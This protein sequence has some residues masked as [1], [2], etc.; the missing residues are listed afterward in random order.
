M[1]GALFKYKCGY[2][3]PYTFLDILFSNTK[4]FII[5]FK[6]ALTQQTNSVP[7]CTSKPEKQIGYYHPHE[8]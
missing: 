2:I 4:I 8:C 3:H 1:I 6:P 7:C 5:V